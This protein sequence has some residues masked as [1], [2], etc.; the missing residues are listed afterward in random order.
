[1]NISSVMN[2][3]YQ[4]LSTG[5]AIN[6]A[7]DNAAGLQ[8]SQKLDSSIRGMDQ[9]L[10]NTSAMQDLTKTAESALGNISDQLG[11]MRELAVQASNGLLTDSDKSVIQAEISQLKDSVAQSAKN[12]SFNTMKLLDGSFANK[13]TA[14]NPDGTGKQI[15]I[16]SASLENLGISNFDVTGSF[17]VDTIDQALAKVN[18]SRANLGSLSNAF[19]T[20][21]ASTENSRVNL[22]ASKSTLTDTDMAKE[23][24]NLRKAQVL[25]QYKLYT[26]QAKAERQRTEL[27]MVQDFRL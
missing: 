3:A 14:M 7:A 21:R 4:R 18:T 2:N 10:N 17:S 24:S 8:I 19:D 6:K 22:T 25:E 20:A 26:Q 15:S 5:S 27:G 12:T 16:A 13:N 9:N 1:M 11:R 23:I